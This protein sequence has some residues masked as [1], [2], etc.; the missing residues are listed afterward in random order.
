MVY[1]NQA[2]SFTAGFTQTLGASSA[3]AASLNVPNTG[4]APSSPNKGDM[5]LTGT[6][7]HL[8]FQDKSGTTQMLAF[9]SDVTSA[10][11]STLTTAE[12]F[13]TTA[14]NNAQNTAQTFATNAANNAQSTAETFA[15]NA[16]NTA[17]AN[18]E[19]FATSAATTA[20]NSAE[21]FSGNASNITS[22]TLGQSFL[23]NDVVYNN[24]ANTYSAGKKQTFQ[25]DATNA[26]LA[27]GGVTVNPSALANGD[28]WYRSD[29][30]HV[31]LFD[32]TTAHQFMFTDDT[33]QNSQLNNSAIS[34][35]L[36]I[37]L[38]G[39]STVSLGGTL[40]LTN[41]GVLSFNGRN[42]AV[43][44]AA[45]DYSFSQINIII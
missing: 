16:A 29:T 32:G 7:P 23:P 26:G 31:Q 11:A 9:S 35:S 3:T 20:L 1:N 6:D 4:A 30:K 8:Q 14:A 15:T 21:T 22:G 2:N 13:A 19:T 40:S 45:N 10:N 17:Q 42:G 27:F 39:S 12:T 18:A 24:Q 25:T 5:W 41:S 43:A 37:G 36:G 44:P 34:V 38:S 33:I 28:V